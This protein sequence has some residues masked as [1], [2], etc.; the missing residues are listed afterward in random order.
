MNKI[1][2]KSIQ[3]VNFVLLIQP[4]QHSP[5][6]RDCVDAVNVFHTCGLG[7]FGNMNPVS[8][9]RRERQIGTAAGLPL[10]FG[11]AFTDV[12]TAGA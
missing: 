6:I 7:Q 2:T 1:L 4:K 8:L 5:K 11:A 3:G 10:R 9:K 12:T